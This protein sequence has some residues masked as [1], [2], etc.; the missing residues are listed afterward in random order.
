MTTA[1]RFCQAEKWI[2]LARE[3]DSVRLK[4]LHHFHGS[5]PANPLQSTSPAHSRLKKM[6]EADLAGRFENINH[7]IDEDKSAGTMRTDL[8]GLTNR[9]TVAKERIPGTGHSEGVVAAVVIEFNGG[10]R[11]L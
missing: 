2:S 1:S 11:F 7:A 5:R 8:G 3:W 9:S 10:N 4:S 6:A